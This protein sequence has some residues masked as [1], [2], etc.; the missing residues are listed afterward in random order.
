MQPKGMVNRFFGFV[1][2]LPASDRLLLTLAAFILFA[3]CIWAAI[4]LDGMLS[5][6]VPA[7]SGT[8]TEGVI[9][10]PRF[11]NPVLAVTRADRD[12]SELIYAGL[13][14]LGEGGTIVP[15]IAESITVSDNGLTYNVVLR[16]DV[17]FHD[18]EHLTADDVAFTVQSIQDP[19][20]ASPLRASWAG[21]SVQVVGEY[22]LNFVLEKSYAPFMEN[23][24]VGIL[25][26]H[27]WK[28][29]SAEEFPFS[30]YNSEPIGAGPYEVKNV[31]RDPSG[32]PRAYTL[33]P[34][35]GYHRGAAKIG[36]LMLRFYTNESKVV[37]AWNAHE[38]DSVAGLSAE[39]L[40]ELRLLDD[41]HTLITAPLPRTFAVFFN[42]N[43]SPALRDLGA[44]RALDAAID[45]EDLVETVLAGYGTPISSP[46]VP[47]FGVEEQNRDAD[48]DESPQ[49]KAVAILKDAGWE[50]NDE[51]GIWEK[52]LG[53]D[54]T[55]TPLALSIST[56]NSPVFEATAEYLRSK[57]EQLGVSVTVKQFEQSDLTQG[58]IRPR[59]YEALLFGTVIGRAFDF[60]SFWHSSQRNDPGL[61]IALYANI[62]TDA[63]L[64]D[65]RTNTDTEERN[66]AVL[67]FAREI[68]EESP[69]VFLYAPEFTYVLPQRVTGA[70][71]TGLAEPYE[72]FANVNEW[73]M[74]TE[75]IWPL[76]R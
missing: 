48:D 46:I 35:D 45:R 72:R 59:D 30:Q 49:E 29:A 41:A 13:A 64:E 9:G 34:Y 1:H 22:E 67:Q 21:V 76:F 74:T 42:Q 61:N 7:E 8:L 56:A 26:E 37:D 25:P 50:L 14:R 71:F 27:I 2:A 28:N 63:V 44:R 16:Q 17:Y 6:S 11:I 36:V 19:A 75:S 43:K 33:V 53:E 23:L 12:L 15:D 69:A 20:I 65:I 10:T 38:I 70:S 58:V 54:E 18:G 39:A 60:Y 40:G 62:T 51:T 24:T 47:G 4:T 31:D 3:S 66:E 52:E 57:W 5:S 73:Y 68:E 32:I 55:L